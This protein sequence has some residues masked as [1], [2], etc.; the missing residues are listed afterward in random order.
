V[1]GLEDVRAVFA[2]RVPG[3]ADGPVDGVIGHDALVPYRG[4]QFFLGNDPAVLRGQK[5]Q[6]V[7]RARFDRDVA[8]ASL[9]P[10]AT[11]IDHEA[12]NPESC[13]RLLSGNVRCCHASPRSAVRWADYCR[14]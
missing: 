10:S 8:S 4:K 1:D 12:G 6:H 14:A 7:E 11:G 5:G 3:E 2:E 9:Y 13:R